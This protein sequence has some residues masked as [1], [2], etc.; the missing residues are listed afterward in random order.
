MTA[1]RNRRHFR[2][3]T[4]A[5]DP[6]NRIPRVRVARLPDP[7]EARYESPVAVAIGHPSPG[8]ARGENVTGARIVSPAAVLERAP[9]GAD[10]V[11]LPDVPIARH[12][13][14]VAVVIQVAHAISVGRGNTGSTR[15]SVTIVI[16]RLL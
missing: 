4:G 6:R 11:G 15:R 5:R 16:V 9:V 3:E 12:G 13:H 7:P 10:E 8:I 1:G 2:R 14:K